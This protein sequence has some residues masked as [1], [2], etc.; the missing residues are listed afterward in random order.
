MHFLYRF[1]RKGLLGLR[2]LT[3][4]SVEN[5]INIAVDVLLQKDV[6]LTKQYVNRKSLQTSV[7]LFLFFLL[8]KQKTIDIVRFIQKHIIVIYGCGYVSTASLKTLYVIFFFF[9]QDGHAYFLKN[10][11]LER[12][13][14]SSELSDHLIAGSMPGTHLW[15]CFWRRSRLYNFRILIY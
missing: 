2:K 13:F 1:L 10:D 14:R 15:L 7:C 3:R 11:G 4:N 5:F 12:R 6:I 9:F 8:F